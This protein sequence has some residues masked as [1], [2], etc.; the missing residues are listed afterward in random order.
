MNLNYVRGR[1]KKISAIYAVAIIP[2]LFM[3]LDQAEQLP[4][5]ETKL[6]AYAD[7]FTGAAQSQ[8]CYI[9]GTSSP[10]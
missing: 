6:V 4:G 9:G 1:L 8:I 2:L 5:K 7:N 10:H 3:L